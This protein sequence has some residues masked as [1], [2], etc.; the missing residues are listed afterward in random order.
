M[1]V[2]L[3]YWGKSNLLVTRALRVPN[4]GVE[5]SI[6]VAVLQGNDWHIAGKRKNHTTTFIFLINVSLESSQI[7]QIR[8]LNGIPQQQE[9]DLGISWPS[10]VEQGSVLGLGEDLLGSSGPRVS[11]KGFTE[12]EPRWRP[13]QRHPS[14]Q[15]CLPSCAGS[16]HARVWPGTGTR[17]GALQSP[18]QASLPRRGPP[19]PLPDAQR[20]SSQQSVPDRTRDTSARRVWIT[21]QRQWG[22]K[23]KGQ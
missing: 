22:G 11:L 6:R 9:G 14:W 5:L 20:Q 21:G 10:P 17:A 1:L 7:A 15:C 19:R 16:A 2:I 8:S 3:E 18:L 12:A 13:A 4:S 23:K